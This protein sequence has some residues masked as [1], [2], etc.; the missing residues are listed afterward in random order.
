M[1][2]HLSIEAT[3]SIVNT[4][5]AFIHNTTWRGRQERDKGKHKKKDDEN[6]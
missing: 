4:C 1:A 5:T 3:W 2:A 6:G